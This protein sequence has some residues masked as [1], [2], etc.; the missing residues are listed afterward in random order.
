MLM[1]PI[2]MVKQQ[3]SESNI[4]TTTVSYEVNK[5]IKDDEIIK[6]YG[7]KIIISI[8][9]GKNYNYLSICKI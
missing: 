5:L 4:A 8:F 2:T 3:N 1:S 9:H 7:N 6:N